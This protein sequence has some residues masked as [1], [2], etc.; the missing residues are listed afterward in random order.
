[1]TKITL[2]DLSSLTSNEQSAVNL[3]NANNA[4]IE[5]ASDNTL[6]R[7]GTSPNQMLA[8]LDMNS[9]RILNLPTPSAGTDPLRLQDYNTLISGG[10]VTT[11]APTNASYL[12][13]AT[14]ATL[15]NE[16]VFTPGR[17]LKSTDAGV[18]S[19]YTVANISKFVT[20]EEFGAVGDGAADDT[21]SVQ[22]AVASCV[23]NNT[24]LF[25]SGYYKVTST[26]TIPT[27]F[28]GLT[29]YGTGNGRSGFIT[30]T[31]IPVLTFNSAGG[32]IINVTVKDV[33]FLGAVSGTSEIG[34]LF[35]GANFI[36][37][38]T[39]SG[40][41]F[42]NIYA[43]FK[44]T[45]AAKVNWC[46]FDT[47]KVQEAT[48]YGYLSTTGSG[49]GNVF[50]SWTAIVTT[51]VIEMG[52]GSSSIGDLTF[53]GL[54]C[55]GT[56]AT[57]IKLTGGSYNKLIVINGCQ[58]DGGITTSISLTNMERISGCNNYGGSTDFSISSGCRGLAGLILTNIVSPTQIA[59]N[60]NNYSPT[61]LNYARQLN[62]TSD[63]SRDITGVAKG[64]DGR[65]LLLL[66]KG[67]QNIVLKHQNA[68]STA[69]NRFSFVSG[70]DVTLSPN[71]S[72]ELV[73]EAVAGF[74]MKAG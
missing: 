50:S 17:N 27:G 34:I 11:G 46:T 30:T 28:T 12:T 57:G 21:T 48:N 36:Q 20:P 65:R 14:N 37:H 25:L 70:L 58:F 13:L 52:D 39:F 54:Q 66:N 35:T 6:S 9:Q 44:D 7:D 22:A 2:N 19:T 24:H 56:S 69:T 43:G 10:T 59:A 40:L 62:L 60:Q 71:M 23:T 45:T 63:A 4:L 3:I 16:R 31:N 47:I 61:D 51:S 33:L 18:G 41:R 72:I 15:S 64:F 73:Y 32:I 26:I 5:T 49:T 68:S 1:M 42:Y 38:C 74:W 29:I 8:D 55:G 67:A 53:T